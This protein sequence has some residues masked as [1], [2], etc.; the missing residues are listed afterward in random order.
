MN[1]A[2]APRAKNAKNEH[3][4][5]T[6]GTNRQTNAKKRV[7]RSDLSGGHG[8]GGLGGSEGQGWFG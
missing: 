4:N 5:S 1:A 7:G 8:W 6:K 3:H 2:I